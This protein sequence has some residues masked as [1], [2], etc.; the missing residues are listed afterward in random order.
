MYVLKNSVGI[1][2]TKGMYWNRNDNLLATTH[3]QKINML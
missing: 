2:L 1:V 3:N